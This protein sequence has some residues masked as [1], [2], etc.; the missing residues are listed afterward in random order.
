MS[1]K[2]KSIC[3]FCGAS[4]SVDEH[5]LELARA[6]GKAIAK[7]K[8]RLVYGG[9][10]VGLMGASAR[11]AHQAG[12]QVLG[13]IPSFLTQYEEVLEEIEH[14]IV[15]DMHERKHQMYEEAD[16]FMV[17]P[18]GIGTL[19]E[20]IEIMSWMRLHLHN[21]PLIFVDTDG[22]WA[23]LL[24]LLRFTITAKFSPAWLSGHL[25]YE[26]CPDTA[27]NLIEVQ[28][29]NPAPKGNIQIKDV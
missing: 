7:R 14:R 11:A 5:Y 26:Q 18:G 6:T 3:V 16:A 13:I 21:K 15:N 28:W 20:A 1:L 22:Y 12:G 25:F 10:G 2:Q 24:D 23:G 19:E 17:L 8:Y 29:E 4:Q 27:L 9:G